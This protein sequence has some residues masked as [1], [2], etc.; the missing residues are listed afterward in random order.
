M[1]KTESGC[2]CATPMIA[3]TTIGPGEKCTVRV[4]G[5]GFP[6]GEKTVPITLHTDSTAEPKVVLEL[7]MIGSRKPPFL[8]EV[9]A[10]LGY[11]GEISREGT[12]ELTAIVI[13]GERPTKAPIPRSDLPF[14]AFEPTGV[15]TAPYVEPGTFYHTYRYSVKFTAA[16][17]DDVF[18]GS[19]TVG[20]PW[21]AGHIERINVQGAPIP[22]LRV[23]PSRPSLSVEKGRASRAR[24]NFAIVAEESTDRLVVT[25]EDGPASLF[26]VERA[27][28]GASGRFA[29]FV[30]RLKD[31]AVPKCGEYRLIASLGP[32]S[33]SV[34]TI[35]VKTEVDR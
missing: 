22:L 8:L 24:A 6:I 10:D 13:E 31:G 3:P 12:R 25:P 7:R 21:E 4:R 1:L 29:P 18:V 34:F 11:L 16:P 26:V 28:S 9:S 35:V 19:V 5:R 14:L 23:I 32:S 17:P 27:A 33:R 30:V 15:K 20:D 2:G